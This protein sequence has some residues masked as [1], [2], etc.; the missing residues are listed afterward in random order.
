MTVRVPI[1]LSWADRATTLSGFARSAADVRSLL[2]FRAAALRGPVRIA[3]VLWCVVFVAITVLAAWLPARLD[4]AGLSRSDDIRSLLP[5]AFAGLLI[6]MTIAAVSGGGRELLPPEQAAAYPISATTDHLGTL[7]LAPLNVAW[8]VQAWT[9]LGT[10]AFVIGPGRNLLAAQVP[11]VL[12][13]LVSTVAAQAFSW[14]A[15]WLRRGPGG[16]WLF[17]SIV[18]ALAVFATILVAVSDRDRLVAP[19]AWILGA[20]DAGAQGRWWRWLS[21][22]VVLLIVIIVA[23]AIGARIANRVARRPARE[24]LR[25][26]SA[27]R[28]PRADAR[29]DLAALVRIDR[30]GIWR[31]VPIRRGFL[32]LALLPGLGA[33]AGGVRWEMV[34]ILPG[35]VASAAAL[36]FGVN[37]WNLDGRGAMWRA[38]LPVAPRVAFFSR[39][40]ALLELVMLGLLITI[41]LACLRAGVPSL[42][43]LIAVLCAIAVGSLQVVS[44]SMRWSVRR[45]FAIDMRSARAAPAPPLAMVGYSSRLAFSTTL[46]GFAF[47][48]TSGTSQWFWSPLIAAPLLG[49]SALGVGRAARRWEDPVERSRVVTTVAA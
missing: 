47:A 4:G 37:A 34:C 3:M 23:T 40:I 2:A 20:A 42:T 29:S 25:T 8:L 41:T 33:L 49:L 1:A 19:A 35:P 45:P 15:E 22:V 9:L 6:L 10:T 14:A 12:F 11:I 18:A 26:E 21:T 24:E 48:V 38:S 46:T 31:S 7:L 5:T 39:A 13:V 17:R 44:A 36:L 30:A 28:L 43:Q 27:V 16:I 32:V